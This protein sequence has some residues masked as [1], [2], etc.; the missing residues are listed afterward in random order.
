MSRQPS[1]TLYWGPVGLMGRLLTITRHLGYIT[2]NDRTGVHDGTGIC[3]FFSLAAPTS[4]NLIRSP[5]EQW[6]A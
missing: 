4:R 6:G 1:P 2:C 5:T 3:Y